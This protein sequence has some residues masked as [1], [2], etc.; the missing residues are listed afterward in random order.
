[1]ALPYDNYIRFL[2]TKGHV[3]LDEVNGL[4]EN[5]SLPAIKQKTLDEHWALVDSSL[6]LGVKSQLEN[7][8]QGG[9]E[10]LR[11]MAFLEVQ[12]YWLAEKPFATAERR[13]AVRITESIHDDQMLRLAINALFIKGV[14]PKEMLQSLSAKYPTP[15]RD[16]HLEIYQAMFWNTK[17]MHRR[18]WK[19]YIS[20]VNTRE[21]SVY[22]LA[23]TDTL[24]VVKTELE[25]P[26]SVSV[27]NML[28]WLLSKSFQKAKTLIDV[29]SP[30]AAKE[31]RL[32]IDKAIVLAD[33]YE[34]YRSTDQADLSQSLQMEFDFVDT[35]FAA[36]D[37]ETL[38]EV[39]ERIKAKT[40]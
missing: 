28:Q 27:S 36:P 1:M 13:S 31:A 3:D 10:F 9:D 14:Q 38:R 26:S 23:L 20:L 34:K 18:D 16:G 19:S 8:S 33:K 35:E 21:Q 37:D 15:L 25:L 32:W 4:L 5:F 29:N 11:W 40:T 30:D 22:F 6:P 39:T 7:K 24:D 17:R 12:D 2:V